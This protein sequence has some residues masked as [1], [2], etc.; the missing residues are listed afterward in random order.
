MTKTDHAV[1][2]GKNLAISFD[3]SMN[4]IDRLLVSN[5]LLWALLTFH[6][7]LW[8]GVSLLLD[9][10]PDMAD[11]W[12]WS[13]FLAFGYYEH[14]PMVAVTMRLAT[15]IGGNT[16]LTLKLGS[17]LFSVV[18]L[19]LG[20]QVGRLYFNRRTALIFV[21]ILE[22]TPYFSAGSVFW[23]INQPY[24]V[25]WLLGM[26]LIHRY[27]Q[28]KNLNWMIAFGVVAGLGAMSKYIM[29]LFP[30]ALLIWVLINPG[31]RPILISAKTYL[32]ALLALLIVAPNI[33]WNY[34]RD[35]VTFLFP[36][37]KGLTG[38]RFGEHFLHFEVSQLVLFSLFFSTLFWWNFFKGRI[39]TA[40]LLGS[41]SEPSQASFSLLLV[42]GILPVL[43][44]SITSFAGS[45]TDPSWVNVAYFSL[46]LLLARWIDIQFD[47][48]SGKRLAIF[49]LLAFLF[50]LLITA[51]FLI[52][53]HFN[54]LPWEF[55]D[56]P[57][58]KSLLG[59]KET[60]RQI[61][62][63]YERGDTPL[64]SY[65]ISREYQVSSALSFYLQN[66]PIPHSL[67]KIRRN[68]WSPV[69][70]VSEKGA[71]LV[72]VPDECESVLQKATDR[73][74]RTL[75]L[76]GE[77]RVLHFGNVIRELKLYRLPPQHQ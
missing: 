33:Y 42:L 12:V 45:R 58:L 75:E 10:H 77:I 62:A 65:I 68:A 35:W 21:A 47:R 56:A 70:Q 13:R 14:P 39:K 64:P 48:G 2:P 20:Y 27:L 16:E 23:H 30:I 73:F 7:F 50:N 5:R 25:C 52:H 69:E 54:L 53:V 24:M 63:I 36:L 72:C 46:F 18:I 76:L 11:H 29:I 6:F 22:C 40:A 17:V 74:Q 8:F 3:K 34:Q 15:L 4:F 51:G 26:I 43:F 57:S 59:W 32:G 1:D 37:E 61:E 28:T 49:S 38:A 9:L 67:E 31:L 55:P 71:A 19:A 66:Q 41:T 44:F 60:A